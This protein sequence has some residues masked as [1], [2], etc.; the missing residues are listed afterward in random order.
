[1]AR[2]KFKTLPPPSTS[3]TATTTTTTAI[4]LP[5]VGL[6]PLKRVFSKC[7]MTTKDLVVSEIGL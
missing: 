7:K 2:V 6:V 1:M 4:D 5:A 3:T